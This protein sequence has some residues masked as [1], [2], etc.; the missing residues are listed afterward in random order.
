MKKEITPED[1]WNKD[2]MEKI[3][4]FIKCESKK[5]SIFRKI[6]NKYLSIKYKIEDIIKF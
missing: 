6:K 3:D 2:K 1:I 4:T 5:Q